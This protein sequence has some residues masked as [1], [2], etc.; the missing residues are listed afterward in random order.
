MLFIVLT[1][2]LV[3]FLLNTEC[4]RIPPVVRYHKCVD[5]AVTIIHIDACCLWHFLRSSLTHSFRHLTKRVQ[6]YC[7][8]LVGKTKHYALRI[9]K[10]PTFQLLN[11]VQMCLFYFFC[12]A[13]SLHTLNSNQQM[14]YQ[15]QMRV[16]ARKNMMKKKNNKLISESEYNAMI[17]THNHSAAKF[18]EILFVVSRS[19]TIRLIVWRVYPHT[20]GK[21][22]ICAFNQRRR[23][24]HTHTAT[25]HQSSRAAHGW[26]V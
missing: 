13:S 19:Q 21:T 16:W 17:F 9:V 8:C 22:T 14:C 10:L 6:F 11:I 1:I 7:Y 26:N 25:A 5:F 3:C 2:W 20:F 12:S 24:S 15:M 4:E 18:M 23:H